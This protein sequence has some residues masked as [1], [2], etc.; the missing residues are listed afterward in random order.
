MSRFY[1]YI[2]SAE[3]V[4]KSYD[5]NGPLISHLKS[6]FSVHKQMGGRDR[7]TISHLCYCFYRCFF[8]FEHLP[9]KDRILNALYLCERSSHPLLANIAPA[10][11]ETVMLAIDQ[12][13]IILNED[14]TNIFP[15]MQLLT[16]KLDQELFSSSLL[17][18]PNLHVR[19]R[20]GM[21]SQVTDKLNN[22]GIIFSLEEE[23][24]TLANGTKLDSVIS[25]NEEAI[26][27]DLNSQ[28]VLDY[29]DQYNAPHEPLRAW[30]CC[31]ASGG[32]SILLADK[33]K[34]NYQLTVSDIRSSILDNLQK[35]LEQAKVPLY[36]QFVVD[37]T[38]EPVPGNE[39]DIIIA[40][41]PCTGSGTWARTPEQVAFFKIK[42]AAAYAARQL[43][44]AANAFA[45]L[46]PGGMF[47]YITCSVFT[48][49]NENVIDA[50]SKQFS[51]ELLEMNYLHG[52][53]KKADSLFVAVLRKPV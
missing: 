38:N 39:Y 7:K 33:V 27:Q 29:L 17:I 46:A 49:E 32:K 41:V 4:I 9:M 2:N 23:C 15:F 36:K 24:I 21:T 45:S 47:F 18:Q 26:V 42:T 51:F 25:L 52:Y 50:L 1:S 34:G 12:K 16:E 31:A 37:L 8:L 48:I 28:K 30:D 19:A 10:L 20:P 5:G 40:D 13:L 6:F 11:D 14:A 35:R 53:D 43:K 22:A 44:I 3:N